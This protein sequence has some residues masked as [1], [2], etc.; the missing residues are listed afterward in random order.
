MNTTRSKGLTSP[1]P[2]PRPFKS[3][4]QRFFFGRDRETSELSSLISAHREVVVY[5]QSGAGKSSLL[6]AALIPKLSNEDL[7][8]LPTARVG[9]NIPK[10][11]DLSS[12]DNVYVFATLIS[13]G[14]RPQRLKKSSIIGNETSGTISLLRCSFSTN[15]K[16]FSQ[17]TQSGGSN[18]STFLLSCERRW[19][20][21]HSYDWCL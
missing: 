1:Y 2:G 16:K 18:A 3:E 9:G 4:E 20:R 5:A 12:V 17:Y 15:L 7:D 11:I 14:N 10:Q 21:I 8:V 19:L 6:N 13:W